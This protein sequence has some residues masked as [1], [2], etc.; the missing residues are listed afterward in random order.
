[1]QE[2]DNEDISIEC[3]GQGDVDSDRD[4]IGDNLLDAPMAAMV[5]TVA[6]ERRYQGMNELTMAVIAWAIAII[7]V[8]G[9][10]AWLWRFAT[11]IEEQEEEEQQ[12]KDWVL[13]MSYQYP[14]YAWQFQKMF[15]ERFLR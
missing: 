5:A 8:V 14:Q 1:M 6:Q 7:C 15:D 3:W 13:Q 9:I 4:R 11:R 2:Q 12:W 10:F